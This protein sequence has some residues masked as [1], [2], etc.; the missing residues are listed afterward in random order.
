M[1]G[2]VGTARVAAAS[3]A[4]VLATAVPGPARAQSLFEACDAD[5]TA[6]CA[7]VQ[8]GNGRLAACLY[9]HEDK[10]SDGCDAAIA[11]VADMLDQVFE[12]YR[13]AKQECRADIET[14][15]AGVA[16][17][18]GR[19]MSCL[20]ENAG[21]LSAECGGVLSRVAAPKE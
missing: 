2:V 14:L 4:V 7:D 16:K 5:I 21:K 18:G 12:V 6:R 17:G 9:A 1:I 11:E 20:K 10:L 8:P 15:C 19:I 3:L 13:Y